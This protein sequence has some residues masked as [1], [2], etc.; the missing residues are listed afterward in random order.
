MSL[1]SNALYSTSFLQ[2]KPISLRQSAKMCG[3]Y[4]LPPPRLR[5][6]CINNLVSL[7][8]GGMNERGVMRFCQSFP[9]G[10][11]LIEEVVHFSEFISFLNQGVELE[12]C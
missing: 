8:E 4:S 3:G 11:V 6:P 5:R 12:S 10:E 7:I 2:G 9:K 1:S